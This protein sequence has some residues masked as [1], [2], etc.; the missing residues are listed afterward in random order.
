MVNKFFSVIEDIFK[1]ERNV[2]LILFLQV[3]TTAW[4]CG[5]YLQAGETFLR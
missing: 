3:L 5:L 1:A 2:A 4:H